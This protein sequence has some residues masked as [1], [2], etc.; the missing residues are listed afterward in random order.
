MTNLDFSIG[1]CIMSVILIL[2]GIK[3]LVISYK[4]TMKD[5]GVDSL[6]LSGKHGIIEGFLL[7]GVSLSL[8][9]SNNTFIT[10]IIVIILIITMIINHFKMKK[11]EK[12]EEHK[13]Y[14]YNINN[15]K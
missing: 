10:Y 1:L 14:D 6:K 3:A 8:I 11:C 15:K 5:C 12:R 2:L 7:L 4:P 9:F 13:I